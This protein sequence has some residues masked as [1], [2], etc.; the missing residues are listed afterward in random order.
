MNNTNLLIYYMHL[1][2][3]FMNNTN[4]LIYYMHLKPSFTNEHISY[5]GFRYIMMW[6]TKCFC[7]MV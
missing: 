5:S 2:P 6:C 3:S 4:L 7:F 1:K